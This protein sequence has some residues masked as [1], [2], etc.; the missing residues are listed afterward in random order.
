MES[1]PP[2]Q[3]DQEKVATEES[4]QD[5][6]TGEY[7]GR[8]TSTPAEL[9]AKVKEGIAGKWYDVGELL[10]KGLAYVVSDPYLY[11]DISMK[12]GLD[13]ADG[14]H[15]LSQNQEARAQERTERDM[16]ELVEPA[17]KLGPVRSEQVMRL[18]HTSQV[19]DK[20]M[21]DTRVYR[22]LDPDQKAVYDRWL[23]QGKEQ[24]ADYIK[25]FKKMLT[26]PNLS[27]Q[28]KSQIE[29]YIAKFDAVDN[30]FPFQRQ[31]DYRLV[32]KM[33]NGEFYVSRSDSRF[34]LKKEIARA[35]EL[36]WTI[37]DFSK[38][39]DYSSDAKYV[40]SSSDYEGA[41]AIIDSQLGG[42]TKENKAASEAL[43]S[44]M[45]EMSRPTN[46]KKRTKRRKYVAGAS[47][48]L[49]ANLL[50]ST[51]HHN[52]IMKLE[53]APTRAK[54]VS[55]L[56]KQQEAMPK[57]DIDR[58]EN[59]KISVDEVVLREKEY[60]INQRGKVSKVATKI[61]YLL[62]LAASGGTAFINTLHPHVMGI[63]YLGKD[64]GVVAA[65]G[66]ILKAQKDVRLGFHSS[67]TKG[68]F[69]ANMTEDEIAAAHAA[70]HK[71]SDTEA[72]MMTDMHDTTY[73][74]EYGIKR[75]VNKTMG[76][77]QHR[78]EIGNREATFL[79]AFRLAKRAGKPFELAKDEAIASINKVNMDFSEAGKSRLQRSNVGS[80]ITNFKSHPI[81]MAEI[82]AR[83]IKKIIG[84]WDVTPEER[85]EAIYTF[86]G[87]QIMNFAYA[88][89]M[90]VPMVGAIGAIFQIFGDDDENLEEWFNKSLEEAGVSDD[91][92]FAARR[93]MIPAILGIDIA[94]RV[95]LG[96][97]LFRAPRDASSAESW[98]RAITD[99]GGPIVARVG[100]IPDAAKMIDKGRYG[101]AFE[102]MISPAFLKNAKKAYDWGL[103][104]K[105]FDR[106]NN[107]IVDEFNGTDVFKQFFGVSPQDK[108]EATQEFYSGK[109]KD[110]K[111][112][113]KKRSLL[114]DMSFAIVRGDGSDR[115]EA[116]AAIR[117][118]NRSNRDEKISASSI[119]R[120]VNRFRE[121]WDE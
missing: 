86:S 95:G 92:N 106:Y 29:D 27:P 6:I 37:E 22:T 60:G 119:K 5:P 102:T 14:L 31:G 18:A 48:N 116:R 3:Q 82:Q 11:E 7:Q 101:D 36:G 2:A 70:R 42:N 89:M 28:Q 21:Q 63:P 78:T 65:T 38:V 109:A 94:E 67:K 20:N 33:D 34:Q 73:N 76:Y 16:K 96:G 105:V 80:V 66:A 98:V 10:N 4:K 61:S 120:S 72:A 57:T 52:D 111:I 35:E 75:M 39:V 12:Y 41:Q 87:L 55:N 32:A 58:K 56:I 121:D 54:M 84:T 51:S 50:S 107:T 117:E 8:V 71:I 64:Y 23:Q 40:M 9:K 44:V 112:K 1:L 13:A 115:R 46:L 118:W 90:G 59:A 26:N 30:Y 24:Q 15:E 91:V 83:Q 93:G 74:A 17:H 85:R 104:D 88:G 25:V 68:M 45:A 99:A 110:R 108:R 77:L 114:R 69:S 100:K 81:K 43:L 49:V 79:A 62:H 53:Y 19:L 97:S 47:K 113:S 103:E